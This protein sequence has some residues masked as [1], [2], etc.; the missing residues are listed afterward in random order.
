MMIKIVVLIPIRWTVRRRWRRQ[1]LAGKQMTIDAKPTGTIT[2]NCPRCGNDTF[3]LL[4]KLPPETRISE[5]LPK[6][7]LCER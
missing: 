3:R 2:I 1:G 4:G 7:R 6:R 5:R